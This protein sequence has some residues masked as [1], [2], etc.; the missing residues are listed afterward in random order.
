M[1][2]SL[3][4]L[5]LIATMTAQNA[6]AREQ[7]VKLPTPRYT[8]NNKQD[9]I[10]FANA[11][12]G[13][14]GNGTGRIFRTDNGGDR[15]SRVWE[16]RGTYVRAL[17]FVDAN[18]GFMG[19][20]G[21]GYFPNVTDKRA[22][23]ATRDGGNT[24]QPVTAKSGPPIVG[25]CAIDVLKVD[26]R[27]LAI[28]AGGR[29]GG[30]AGMI[31]SFDGGATWTSR[32]MRGVTGMILD[33]KFVDAGTGFIAGASEADEEKAR[34]RI[35]KTVDGGKTWH[36]VFE[37]DR[38][39]DNNWKLSFPTSKTGYATI[40][41]YQAPDDEARGYVL[42]TTDGGEHWQKLIVT[43]DKDWIPYGIGFVDEMKGFVGGSSGGFET[44]DGGATWA[45]SEMGTSVNKFSF[46]PN[47]WGGLVAFSVG[48]D[49]RRQSLDPAH[50]EKMPP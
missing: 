48:Q 18:T 41:S 47:G 25:I 44:R 40:I 4:L 33:I 10:S 16:K 1:R 34:A 12:R 30:P 35:L 21:P 14:Y 50:I 9:A 11:E 20:V 8:L 5:S 2:R 6:G 38:K 22:L 26:G 3:L 23:Y 19:N 37:S 32:D 27:V 49:V 43:T 39:G 28:R 29:V 42:K 45:A 46:I 17:S 36:T 31:E 13:F 24:W 7:W 15:W